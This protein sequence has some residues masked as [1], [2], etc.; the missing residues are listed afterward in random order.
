MI[1][2]PRRTVAT[3]ASKHSLLSGRIIRQPHEYPIRSLGEDLSISFACVHDSYPVRVGP[4]RLPVPVGR[5]L[6]FV[7][8]NID[9]R[10][11]LSRVVGG[12]QTPWPSRPHRDAARCGSGRRAPCS[13]GRWERS[14]GLSMQ[15]GWAA[16]DL[17]RRCLHWCC[18]GDEAAFLLRDKMWG[19]YPVDTGELVMAETVL[20]AVTLG[21][22]VGPALPQTAATARL[23]CRPFYEPQVRVGQEQGWPTVMRV[24]SLEQDMQAVSRAGHEARRRRRA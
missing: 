7:R 17:R 21:S 11:V 13:G 14:R 10:V 22:R 24:I 1:A 4:E 16:S 6:T 19:V 2:S 8:E 3:A 12:C 18:P 15:R 23:R 9:Q 20:I 5:V